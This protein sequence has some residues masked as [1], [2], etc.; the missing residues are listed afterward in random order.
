M[1]DAFE[2][3]HRVTL[4]RYRQ[5]APSCPE[6]QAHRIPDRPRAAAAFDGR[7][8][9]GHLQ[10]ILLDR[11]VS[12]QGAAAIEAGQ[13]RRLRVDLEAYLEPT[14]VPIVENIQLPLAGYLAQGKTDP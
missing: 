6:Y 8:H 11:E 1:P 10:A 13:T 7:I 5:H 14:G 12:F 3:Q 2:Y 4:A 9:P